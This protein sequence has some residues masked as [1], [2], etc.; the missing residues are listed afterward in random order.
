[1]A[2]RRQNPNQTRKIY[3]TRKEID[4]TDNQTAAYECN[5]G[6]SQHLP[7]EMGIPK[8][9]IINNQRDGKA[10]YCPDCA[11]TLDFS[12]H[13][14]EAAKPVANLAAD[15]ANPD[16]QMMLR[17]GTFVDI[18]NPNYSQVKISDIAAGLARE[19]RFA[20]Q[21]YGYYPVAAHC[22]IGSMIA[23]LPYAYAFLMHDAAE[24][25]I[26]DIPTPLKR[27]LPDYRRIEALHEAEIAKRWDV[28]TKY[29]P[30]IKLIDHLM[31]DAE[32]GMIR[33]EVF[34]SFFDNYPHEIEAAQRLIERF[35]NKSWERAFIDRF[36][37]IA[38]MHVIERE[39]TLLNQRKAA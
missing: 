17:S 28:P 6:I 7:T 14:A 11:R 4:V 32:R 12:A 25:V 8:G 2:V 34:K 10:I 13:S 27:L 21:I 1:M 35:K 18:A 36:Y 16:H 24:A 33:G 5:C 23:P 15:P 39:K 22:V 3:L 38:P 37:E 30:R 19:C 20:G 29:K 31:L 9:W 26:K